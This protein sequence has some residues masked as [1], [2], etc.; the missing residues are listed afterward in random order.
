MR[1]LLTPLLYICVGALLSTMLMRSCNP[2]EITTEIIKTDTLTTVKVDT[3]KIAQPQ[4]VK[5]IRDTVKI[6]DTIL[7]AGQTFFQEIKEYRDSTYYARVSGINAFLEEI[8]VYPR[9]TIKYITTTE[10]VA[11]KPKRWGLGVTAGLEFNKDGL[12][13]YVGVGISYDL[14]QW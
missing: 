7:I 14:I 5:I 6:T 13:P 10:Y 8:R 9:T 12:Q 11:E 4:A 2:K 1:N 3:V